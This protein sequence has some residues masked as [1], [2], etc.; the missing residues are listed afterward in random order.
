MSDHTSETHG[1]SDA[2]HRHSGDD[3][4]QTEHAAH[5][6]SKA[7]GLTLLGIVF[8]VAAVIIILIIYF[9]S[10]QSRYKAMRQE[11]TTSA[12]EAINAKTDA[13][14]H[15]SGYGWIDR[16]GGVAFVPVNDAVDLVL[17]EYQEMQA[18]AETTSDLAATPD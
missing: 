9:N 3:V 17:V 12:I 8:G 14:A 7:L 5:V 16:E 11:G 4:P 1:Q 10:Y 15:L 18:M 2:W 13:L 6:S